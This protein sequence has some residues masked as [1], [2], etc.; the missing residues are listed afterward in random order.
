MHAFAQASIHSSI[1]P[2]ILCLSL[3]I[4]YI[5]SASPTTLGWSAST[6]C[7]AR[8]V[9]SQAVLCW[10]M[11]CCV[12]PC[13][14]VPCY[15]G[16]CCVGPCCVLHELNVP[17]KVVLPDAI[18]GCVLPKELCM[19]SVNGRLV[20]LLVWS[21]AGPT[22][23]ADSCPQARALPFEAGKCVAARPGQSP[24]TSSSIY[25][26]LYFHNIELHFI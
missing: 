16:P 14:A 5:H 11:L 22:G 7:V 17:E 18:S 15:A 25:S 10:A 1:H 13:C 6:Q 26:A 12:E 24:F 23:G 21:A 4:M 9:L 20:T 19:L 8:A 2:F 3:G